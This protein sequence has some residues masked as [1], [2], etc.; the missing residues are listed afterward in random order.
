MIEFSRKLKEIISFH[1]IVQ[2]NQDDWSFKHFKQ[3]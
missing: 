1:T 2:L 3:V